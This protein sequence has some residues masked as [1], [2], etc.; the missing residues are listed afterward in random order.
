MAS[1]P[2]FDVAVSAFGG[3]M[4][5]TGPESGE[6]VKVGVALVDVLTGSLLYGGIV[7]AL[8]RRSITGKGQCVSTSLLEAQLSGLVNVASAS[9]M[10]GVDPKPM[11]TAHAS[12]VPYQVWRWRCLS[13]K[14][15]ACY[16]L[17]PV[18]SPLCLFLSALCGTPS[19]ASPPPLRHFK[20]RIPLSLLLP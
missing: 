10:G 3:L 18:P 2:A 16:R 4:S 15:A 7:S 17:S 6:P 9:L 19:L 12:I 14:P 11:G 8:L 1:D 20:Q 13:P 5:I